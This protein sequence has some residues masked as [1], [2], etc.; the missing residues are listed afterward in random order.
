VTATPEETTATGGDLPNTETAD[1][2]IPLAI[3]AVLAAIGAIVVAA[4]RRRS[5]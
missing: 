2:T 3:G 1:W 5:R 4:R